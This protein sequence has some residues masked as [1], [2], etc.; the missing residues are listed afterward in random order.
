MDLNFIK[1][2][3]QWPSLS[4]WWLRCIWKAALRFIVRFYSYIVINRFERVRFSCPRKAG[5]FLECLRGRNFLEVLPRRTIS[6]QRS[7]VDSVWHR[8]P[9]I[10]LNLS[11]WLTKIVHPSIVEMWDLSSVSHGE[12]SNCIDTST[13]FSKFRTR[14]LKSRYTIR[15]EIFLNRIN[16][17]LSAAALK[18]YVLIVIF[19][20]SPAFYLRVIEYHLVVMK[21]THF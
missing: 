1:Y 16:Y 7:C 5:T 9:A 6:W 2:P 11:A 21:T 19:Y 10:E 18:K 17:C 20:N 8:Q 14:T 12:L 13:S 4:P 3:I 15:V